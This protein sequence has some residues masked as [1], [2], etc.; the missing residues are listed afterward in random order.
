[1]HGTHL[2]GFPSVHGRSALVF[3]ETFSPEYANEIYLVEFL[4]PD[5]RKSVLVGVQIAVRVAVGT[6]SD[7]NPAGSRPGLRSDFPDSSQDAWRFLCNRR[8][9]RLRYANGWTIGHTWWIK[10]VGCWFY[11]NVNKNEKI[12]GTWTNTNSYRENEAL[13]DIFNPRVFLSYLLY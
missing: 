1:M 9:S 10:K 8:A 6:G 13:S 2:I 11:A 5:S 3:T 7:P 12:G 4:L